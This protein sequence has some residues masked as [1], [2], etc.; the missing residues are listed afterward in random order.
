MRDERSP[1]DEKLDN[2]LNAAASVFAAKGYHHAS[3]RD[4]ARESEV[5]LSGLYYYVQS[6]EE[7]LFL[8]QGRAFDT[9]TDRLEARLDGVCDPRERLRILME[10]HLTYFLDNMPEMKVMSHEADSLSGEFSRGVAEKKRRLVAIA[11]EVIQELRPDCPVDGRVAT[12]GMFGMMNWIYTWY[13]TA[14]DVPAAQLADEMCS[15]FLDGFLNVRDG[16]AFSGMITAE[17]SSRDAR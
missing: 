1:Y 3:I 16:G 9:L 12:F 2:I 10:N 13:H 5:S 11:R 7:L 6:K 15:I 4:V 17:Y 14:R 8:I